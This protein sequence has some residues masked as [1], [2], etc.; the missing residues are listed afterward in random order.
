MIARMMPVHSAPATHDAA[1]LFAGVLL[2]SALATQVVAAQATSGE[3]AADVARLIGLSVAASGGPRDTLGLLVASV[4][5]DSPADQAGL[6]MGSRILAVNGYLVR[7]APAEI[8]QR[9]AADTALARFDRAIR[10][11]PNGGSVA[12]RIIGF[13]RTRTVTVAVPDGRVAS[14]RGGAAPAAGDAAPRVGA[15]AVSGVVTVP[16]AATMPPAAT[17]PAATVREAPVPAAPVTAAP[18]AAPPV[19]PAV[20]TAAAARA[21]TEVAPPAPTA[22]ASAAPPADPG[23]TTR[24]ASAIADLLGDAQLDLRRLSRD[25][26]SLAMSDSLAELDAQLGALRRRLKALAGDAS[27]AARQDSATPVGRAAVVPAVAPAAAPVTAPVSA[28]APAPLPAPAPVV[29]AAPVMAS[30][31]SSVRIAVDGLELTSVSG[32]LAAYIGTQAGSA[33]VVTRAS[34]A[35]EPMRAGDVVLQVDGRAPDPT[36]LRLA[37]EARHHISVLLLRRGRQFTVT[38]GE[39]QSP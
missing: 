27:P 6:T 2:A 37:L 36:G 7:L 31:T 29:V 20:V 1:R 26:H 30:G 24:S 28:P 25:T 21:S 33:L 3:P 13:G 34:E 10:T 23:R 5:R 8:G 11:T 17:T 35:W 19:T 4:T 18:D 9:A 12:L 38:F 22:P 39:Q 16:A 15:P 32:E 14:V